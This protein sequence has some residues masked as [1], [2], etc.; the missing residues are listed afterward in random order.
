MQATI[1]VLGIVSLSFRKVLS[2]FS[3]PSLNSFE[4][5]YVPVSQW[6]GWV[7]YAVLLFEFEGLP[8]HFP[9]VLQYVL[10]VVLE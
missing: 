2:D 3:S 5:T 9:K 6:N 4:W 7:I 10:M 8:N 1:W